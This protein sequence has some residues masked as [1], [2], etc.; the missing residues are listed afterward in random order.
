MPKVRTATMTASRVRM[1]GWWLAATM[2]QPDVAVS[3][4]PEAEARPPMTA[5]RL[6]PGAEAANAA[7]SR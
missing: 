3:A 5:A 6:I 1:T 7:S 2:S 4:M